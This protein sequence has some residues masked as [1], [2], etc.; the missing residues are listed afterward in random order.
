MHLYRTRASALRRSLA[1]L[2]RHQMPILEDVIPGRKGKFG[3]AEPSETKLTAWI[4]QNLTLTWM[5]CS[6]PGHVERAVVAVSMPPLNYTFASRGPYAKIM[7]RLR[8]ELRAD[9]MR[10]QHSVNAGIRTEDRPLG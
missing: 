9:A 2:L 6:S 3:L 8:S 4:L 1:A 5:E 7:R 10:K